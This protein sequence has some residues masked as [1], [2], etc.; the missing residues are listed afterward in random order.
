MRTGCCLVGLALLF[1]AASFGQEGAQSAHANI[2]NA[3]GQKIGT[4]EITST[5]NGVRIKAD[6]MNL[7]PGTHAIHIHNVGKC[8]GPAF[9]SAGPHFNP[10]MHQHGFDNPQGFHMGD[11]LNF[12]VDKDGK[13]EIDVV[14]PDLTI[15]P[16]PNS[17]FHDG[18]TSLVIHANADDYKSDP[19]GN[20][21]NRIA[22]GVIEH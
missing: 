8:E 3:Q 6:L 4:A 19:A 9:Q 13:G 15:K 14:V 2:A 18:G 16:G 22:C 20:S 12:D 21:G 10:A 17:M 7:P 11:L 5:A 1:A